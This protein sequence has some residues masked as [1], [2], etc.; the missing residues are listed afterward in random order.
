MHA[1][2]GHMGY[3]RSPPPPGHGTGTPPWTWDWDPPLDIGLG[4]PPP[5]TWDW[6][7]PRHGTGTP[8]TGLGPPRNEGNEVENMEN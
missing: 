3:P 7:P 5:Q 8:Q 6:D 4:P 2:I 1:G